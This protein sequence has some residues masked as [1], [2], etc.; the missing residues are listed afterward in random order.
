MAPRHGPAERLR[1]PDSQGPPLRAEHAVRRVLVVSQTHDPG[2]HQFR[3]V[4]T[5]ALARGRLAAYARVV[6]TDEC[7]ARLRM[8]EGSDRLFR[9]M[10][11]SCYEAQEDVSRLL[12]AWVTKACP[13]SQDL[14]SF[15][16]RVMSELA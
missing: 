7:Q 13:E 8:A 10:R 15:S 11:L 12:Q 3:R 5:E 1:R 4:L 14:A 2:Q 9:W 16:R 6:L